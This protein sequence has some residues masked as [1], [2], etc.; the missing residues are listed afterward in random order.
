MKDEELKLQAIAREAKLELTF[1]LRTFAWLIKH[2]ALIDFWE[3]AKRQVEYQQNVL[4][5][6]LEKNK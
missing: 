2:H 3:S 4:N 5:K 1:E 6:V